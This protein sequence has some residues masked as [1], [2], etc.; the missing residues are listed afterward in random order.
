MISHLPE[1]AYAR[2]PLSQRRRLVLKRHLE[3]KIRSALRVLAEEEAGEPSWRPGHGPEVND[4]PL[5]MFY[6]V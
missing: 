1:A 6:G 4:W 2:L 5:D 3:V